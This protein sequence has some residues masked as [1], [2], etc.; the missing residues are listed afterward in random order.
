MTTR[1][2]NLV[3]ER[4]GGNWRV[5]GVFDLMECYF[6]HPEE[7]LVRA[8]RDYVNIGLPGC[9]RA[10]LRSYLANRAPE[11]GFGERWRI[12]MLRDCLL[13]WHFGRRRDWPFP[14]RQ[15]FRQWAE[16]FVSVDPLQ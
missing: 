5:S 16:P 6:G 2:S 3:V 11:S 10:F 7:D 9:A 14:P 4:E 15:S 12:H 8:V 13:I 1:K